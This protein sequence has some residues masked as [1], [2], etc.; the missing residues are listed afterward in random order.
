MTCEVM[1]Y[2]A[3]EVRRQSIS[4]G[5]KPELTDAYKVRKKIE[6]LEAE[7]LR[8]SVKLGEIHDISDIPVLDEPVKKVRL[9]DENGML[10]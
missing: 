2:L 8:L 1:K 9:F 3:F 6:R 7:N 5:V 10:K 4:K